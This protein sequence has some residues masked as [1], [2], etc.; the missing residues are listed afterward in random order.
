MWSDPEDIE[1]WA[2]NT[3]GAGWLFGSGVAAESSFEDFQD[4]VR[5]TKPSCAKPCNLPGEDACGRPQT[6]EGLAYR[7]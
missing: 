4:V 1:T 5:A 6:C 7:Q 2:V 3:R